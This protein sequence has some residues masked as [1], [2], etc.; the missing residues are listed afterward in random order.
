MSD[1][2]IY[3]AIVVD[4][5][6]LGQQLLRYE[7]EHPSIEYWAEPEEQEKLK[8]YFKENHYTHAEP[9][10]VEESQTLDF[11]AYRGKS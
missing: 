11:M 2:S 10:Q 1:K 9:L 6:P 8:R 3:V 5:S 7:F 4:K